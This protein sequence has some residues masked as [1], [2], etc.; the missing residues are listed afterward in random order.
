[1]RR[2][3]P[4]IFVFLF[5]FLQTILHA[6]P[7][8]NDNFSSSSL[9]IGLPVSANGTNQD[10]T[11]ESS[12][13]VPLDFLTDAKA[14][15]WFRWSPSANG[16]VRIEAKVAGNTS[17]VFGVSS[18]LVA[19]WTGSTLEN[20]KPIGHGH[21]G[22]FYD[23][24][25]SLP[26]EVRQGEIYYIAVYSHRFSDPSNSFSLGISQ[27][28]WVSKITGTVRAASTNSTLS[29]ISVSYYRKIAG[30]GN[31]FESYGYST[32]NTDSSGQYSIS[33]LEP[34]MYRLEFNDWKNGDY[35][36]KY[37]GNSTSLE[38]ATDIEVSAE[39]PF[40]VVDVAMENAS[41][42]SGRLT[43]PD[44]ITPLPKVPIVVSLWSPETSW[45]NW[46]SETDTSG[47]YTI[48][49]LSAGSYR[50]QF[51]GDR[52][53][54]ADLFTDYPKIY[55]PEY[56]DNAL[57]WDSA[58][59]VTLGVSEVRSGIDASVVEGGRISGRVTG[60]DRNVLSGISVY[61]FS[62]GIDV[63]SAT[64]DVSGN[65]TIVGLPTGN[66]TVSFSEPGGNYLY[67]SFKNAMVTQGQTLTG[68][69]ASL[70]LAGKISGRVTDI[71][72]D[73]LAGISVY[74]SVSGTHAW[75]AT[76]DSFGNYTVGGLP[77]GNYTVSFSDPAGNYATEYFNNV[78]SWNSANPVEVTQGQTRSGI[79]ASLAIAGKISGRVTGPD[80]AT[81]L[82]GIS[83][84]ASNSISGSSAMTDA[85]GNYTIGGLL[86]SGN[87]TVTF[88]D[89][90]GNY[91]TEY[92]DNVSS[93]NSANP[94]EVTQGQTR[95][96]INAS[97]AIAG[98]ISGRVTGPD[99][100]TPLAGI[101]V[102]AHNPTSAW[103]TPVTTDA[104]GNYT[105][106]GLLPS[107]NYTVR[108]SDPAGNYVTEY[109]DNVSISSWNSANLVEVTQGQTRSGI[110]A[111]LAIA[112]KISGRVTDINGAALAGISVSHSGSGGLT[113]QAITDASGNYTI[114]G[115][116]AGNYTVSFR[117]PNGNYA[118]WTP[119]I[120]MEIAEGQTLTGI[121]ASLAI[122]AKISGHVT[123]TNGAGLAGIYVSAW[124]SGFF[125]Y[126]TTDASGNYT[127][128]DLQTGNYVVQFID[129]SGLYK[130][131]FYNN[132]FV[133]DSAIIINLNTGEER[134]SVNAQMRT[135]TQIYQD[136]FEP[137]S[138]SPATDTSPLGDPDSDGMCNMM[139][140]ALGTDPLAST[141]SKIIFSQAMVDGNTY[142]QLSLDRNPES[143]GIHIEGLSCST[144]DNQSAWSASST[145]IVED[146][147]T[148]FTVRDT[149]PT[150]AGGKRFLRLRFKFQD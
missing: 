74:T 116:S 66:Y 53:F 36:F 2:I 87:Y 13:A 64:T 115:L 73:A 59:T 11:L 60:P 65:Y 106:G 112:A 10:A 58:T 82:A 125:G 139:E 100:A 91:V 69:N 41:A 29:G 136:W 146:T 137:F 95:S 28:D 48:R 150:Q 70:S 38:F 31:E 55:L 5:V 25:S 23:A 24:K 110:N 118:L 133:R 93:W 111:S 147:P 131:L 8:S 54:S 108:F 145:V 6:A 18:P 94:V 88:R 129:T 34:G 16:T 140:Y 44:G 141:Q 135:A 40:P 12:E 130:S 43:C 107:G 50:I 102:S 37:Y 134:T 3:Y 19:V 45:R 51:I 109:F 128:G 120:V 89:H 35:A 122:A 123:D 80:G 72:G 46:V 52:F 121:N 149:V 1:M 27:V 14:S 7:P 114:G 26:I 77:S 103:F 97:M 126:A 148:K 4:I 98:K 47:N 113:W 81:P 127:I 83:V 20:L 62:S 78:S 84:S 85:S 75:G 9:L 63:W 124:D 17:S 142:L 119:S 22:G 49:G 144:L 76:T 30:S 117:D 33:G 68:I 71:N 32:L 42:I 104:S 21:G 92:F 96:G 101:S 57:N 79:N 90:A 56:F 67:E 61:A 99:G 15:V 138:A 132:V 105:I 39:N 143:I 86:P